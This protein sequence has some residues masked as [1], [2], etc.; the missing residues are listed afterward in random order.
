MNEPQWKKIA[1]GIRSQ[2]DSGALKPG[3]RLDNE[4]LLAVQWK[5]SRPTA[6]RAVRELQTLGLVTRQRRWGTVIANPKSAKT[7]RIA[8]VCDIIEQ[9]YDF[10]QANLVRG[11][12]AGLAD[13]HSLLWC[14]SKDDPEREAEL[15]E[16]MSKEADG[17]LCF[18]TSDP[19]NT[20][21]L[22]RLIAE[23]K[24]I[25]LL[26]RIPDGLEATAVLSDNRGATH[27]AIKALLERGHKRIGFL[28]F[29]KPHVS[30]VNERLDS[31]RQ[32]HLEAR[33]NVDEG[34]IRFFSADMEHTH[35]SRFVQAVHDAVFT[36]T[37]Q[38]N[39]VTAIF[40]VQD[41]FAAAVLDVCEQIGVSIP[42]QVELASFNDWPSM[43]L[44][45]P[46]HVHRLIPRT[47]EIGKLAAERLSSSI[48]EPGQAPQVLRVPAEFI[49][50]DAGLLPAAK[51]GNVNA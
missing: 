40:C 5:V 37:Q 41:M 17:I 42:E 44:R 26:D 24:P 39:P 36:L 21:L 22:R 14:D 32:A 45:R 18:P 48:S 8:L 50:A 9:A 31:Y 38:Q 29:Y 1:D 23:G 30:T 7:G 34:L 16:K 15:L 33:T 4:E 47:Y 27:H 51:D 43:M 35:S 6:H 49:L 11:I 12:H 19:R 2:I 13:E 20:P 25:V 3:D 10:P 46:W 28:S